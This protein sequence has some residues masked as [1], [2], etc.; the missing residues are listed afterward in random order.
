MHRLSVF[1]YL[2]GRK[3]NE[4]NP[5]AIPP[6]VTSFWTNLPNFRQ[7]FLA[8]LRRIVRLRIR[9]IMNWHNEAGCMSTTMT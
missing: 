5:C 9:T 6:Y 2:N 4:V 3:N 1:P 8:I 7:V